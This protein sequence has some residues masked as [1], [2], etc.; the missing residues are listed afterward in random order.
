MQE[1][2]TEARG[3]G[4]GYPQAHADHRNDHMMM[5]VTDSEWEDPCIRPRVVSTTPARGSPVL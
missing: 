3:Y 1:V 2:H 5:R 4:Y